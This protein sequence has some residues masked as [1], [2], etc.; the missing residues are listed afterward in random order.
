MN[1]NSNF[2]ELYNDSKKLKKKGN[3]YEVLKK[4][5]QLMGFMQEKTKKSLKTNIFPPKEDRDDNHTKLLI[6]AWRDVLCDAIYFL[7]INDSR[8]TANKILK[9]S[10]N[11]DNYKEEIKNAVKSNVYGIDEIV[12][13]FNQ[14]S[15]YERILY[16]AENYYRD[17]IDHPMY[18]W[19]IGLNILLK[20]AQ[21]FK[22]RVS[23]LFKIGGETSRED[24]LKISQSE[25]GAMWTI[26]A[27][28]H[29]IGY[30]L[31]KVEQINNQVEKM[32][33][34][35]GKIGFSKSKFQFQTQHDHM[36]KFLLNIIS[37]EAIKIQKSDDQNSEKEKNCYT[38]K[39]P[40]YFS[41]FAKS[42]EMFDHG[43][44]SALILMKSLTFFIETDYSNVKNEPI[45]IEDARQFAI[46]AEILHA[47]AA[48]TTPK[49]YHLETNNLS[50]L[51]ILCDDLQEWSRPTFA[52]L[53]NG[54]RGRIKSVTINKFN[55]NDNPVIEC[56]IAYS[57]LNRTEHE[58]FVKR[59][60]RQWLERLRPAL[61]DE[62][63]KFK[64]IW[65]I[66]FDKDEYVFNFNPHLYKL[67]LYDAT[68]SNDGSERKLYLYE[69]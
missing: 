30:P 29:D 59:I 33:S 40:K 15:D 10:I 34:K 19:I 13:Y 65:K 23:N 58:K 28:T 17:H 3:I 61:D 69:D 24:G 14:F 53:K 20:F 21:N 36:V 25:L 16:G 56:E 22:L 51:L 63:R 27:L 67:A 49:I 8:E 1:E 43:I 26:I 46:R 6:N 54:N 52:D 5:H 41:K 55:L 12:D 7:R 68:A 60:F 62:K 38:H 9:G 66:K 11:D 4:D 50:F 35:F 39:R 57:K 48:H 45:G 44:V 47:I 64:F 32:L 31:E 42:W 18:V 37:S 2:L